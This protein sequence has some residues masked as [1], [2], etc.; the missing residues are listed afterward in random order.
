MCNLTHGEPQGV[1]IY[2][3]TQFVLTG[4]YSSSSSCPSLSCITVT[5]MVSSLC[6]PEKRSKKTGAEMLIEFAE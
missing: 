4:E 6:S 5:V 2:A 3:D 1:E